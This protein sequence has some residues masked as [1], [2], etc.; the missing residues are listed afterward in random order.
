MHSLN[1]VLARVTSPCF[2]APR[3]IFRRSPGGGGLGFSEATSKAG[4]AIAVPIKRIGRNQRDSI[5]N[6]LVL[7][8]KSCQGLTT[9]RARECSVSCDEDEN[10]SKELRFPDP[11]G[12]GAGSHR[13]GP[14]PPSPLHARSQRS[15][16]RGDADASA[17]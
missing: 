17:G 13:R 6:K 8:I 1:V 14:I 12:S 4:W 15:A 11:G 7:L 9:C 10:R 3:L 2:T 5:T 16:P